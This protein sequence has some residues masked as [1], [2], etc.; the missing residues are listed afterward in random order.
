MTLPGK[1]KMTQGDATERSECH[2]DPTAIKPYANMGTMVTC[3]NYTMPEFAMDL[4]QA[5]GFFDHPI[6][7]ASG[8][9]GGWNFMIGW[10]SGNQG[11]RPQNA[12]QSG[13]ATDPTGITPYEALERLTGLK[14]VKQKRS[15][16]VIVVDHVDETPME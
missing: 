3:R 12:N 2:V 6:V 1:P 10:S 13:E 8:L 5:T 14:L 16:P 9:K 7:D 4:N 15:I 11:P